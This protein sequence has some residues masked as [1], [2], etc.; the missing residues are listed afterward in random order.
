MPF[1]EIV[2]DDISRGENTGVDQRKIDERQCVLA[3][4]MEYHE[5][6]DLRARTG[7]K[8]LTVSNP[9]L[10]AQGSIVS[11]VVDE[12]HFML[13][14]S[15]GEYVYCTDGGT[16]DKVLIIDV[17][18]PATSHIV[19]SFSHGTMTNPTG[20]ALD[21]TNGLLY[22][23][24][25]QYIFVINI[26]DPEDPTY[27][28]HVSNALLTYQ[29]HLVLVG[30]YLYSADS[31][32]D[33]VGVWD[34]TT[35]AAPTYHTRLVDAVD[36]NGAEGICVDDAGDY[37][38]VSAN[39]N[40]SLT[41]VDIT[42]P[43][44]PVKHGTMAPDATN[45]NELAYIEYDGGADV[46]YGI[47]SP[48][49]FSSQGSLVTIDVSNRAAPA[50]LDKISC[51]SVSL[52]G[53]FSG[54]LTRIGGYAY[55]AVGNSDKI[56]IVDVSDPG[57][58]SETGVI[59]GGNV[60]DNVCIVAL[61]NSVLL[62]GSRDDDLILA[63]T[64]LPSVPPS[65][66]DSYDNSSPIGFGKGGYWHELSDGTAEYYKTDGVD[67][68]I[69]KYTIDADGNITYVGVSANPTYMNDVRSCA[70]Y[71][72]NDKKFLVTWALNST[73]PMVAIWDITSSF[74]LTG[75]PLWYS[76]LGTGS[77]TGTDGLWAGQL[78]DGRFYVVVFVDTS[79]VSSTLLARVWDVDDLGAG[80]V[81]SIGYSLLDDGTSDNAAT[82]SG[83]RVIKHHTLDYLFFKAQTAGGLPY[84]IGVL[85]LTDPTNP[86][87]EA[88]ITPAGFDDFCQHASEDRLYVSNA[89]SLRT[90]NSTDP[91]SLS[92]V[93]TV[94]FAD[95]SSG[96]LC[97]ND[98]ILAL[99]VGSTDTVVAFWLNKDLP[100]KVGYLTDGTNLNVAAALFVRYRSSGG[101]GFGTV[102]RY[103]PLEGDT[104]ASRLTTVSL[105][106]IQSTTLSNVLQ[107][108]YLTNVRGMMGDSNW[109]YVAASGDDAF[110]VLNISD[111]A[112]PY[113]A[114]EIVS[115]TYF[116]A[117]ADV[118]FDEDQDLC[119]TVSDGTNKY[120]SVIDVSDPEN[121]VRLGSVQNNTA[122]AGARQICKISDRYFAVAAFTYDGISIIDINDTSNPTVVATLTDGTELNG[123]SGV[124]SDGTTLW[125]TAELSNQIQPID[126]SAIGTPTLVGTT[127]LTDA[128]KLAGC[129]RL[130]YYDGYLYTIGQDNSYFYVAEVSTPF[131]P[132]EAFSETHA[133]ITNP[134]D[135]WVDGINARAFVASYNNDQIVSY[136]IADPTACTRSVAFTSATKLDGP[137]VVYASGAACFAS[138]DGEDRV[139]SILVNGYPLP[140]PITSIHQFNSIDGVRHTILTAGPAVYEVDLTSGEFT[141]I[142]GTKILPPTAEWHWTNYDG[143]AVGVNGGGTGYDNPVYWDGVAGSISTLADAPT[144][145]QYIEL[146]NHRAVAS[147]GYTLYWS[148]LGDITNWSDPILSG[149]V[150]IDADY[151]GDITGLVA[152]KG[153][154]IIFK[155]NNVW[156]LLPGTPNTDTDQWSIERVISGHGCLN[157]SSA[158]AILDDVFFLSKEGLLSLGTML[159]VGD[160]EASQVS[161]NIAE[162]E[163]LRTDDRYPSVVD[164]VH[165]Q[166]WI[167]APSSG[168]PGDDNNITYVFDFSNMQE[169]LKWTRFTGDIVGECYATG[170]DDA[171]DVVVFIGGYN[172]LFVR[173][174]TTD[175]NPYEDDTSGAVDQDFLSKEV[176]FGV[177][178]KRKAMNRFGINVK[179]LT[180]NLDINFEIRFNG[181][182]SAS[183]SYTFTLD[184]VGVVGDDIE[185]IRKLIG[186]AGKNA[187]SYQYRVRNNASN[188]A[189]GLN[190]L[191]FEVS[192]I[193]HTRVNEV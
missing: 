134:L 188:E 35:P 85:N 159:Q 47:A 81:P 67:D 60:D 26:S 36:L 105:T 43:G 182:G 175:T 31:S 148:K 88:G 153:F 136:L 185:I 64:I 19:G 145:A 90:F 54:Q 170:K 128:T 95:S 37:L 132:T 18:D 71:E 46:V 45:L 147:D 13:A 130:R 102:N 120:V 103:I 154:L 118:Y 98:N 10:T 9:A 63:F 75:T 23:S 193:T 25:S 114:A 190:T 135:I 70:V 14:D 177:P 192:G 179:K 59:Q 42:T 143:V 180:S 61:G 20:M 144:G 29:N 84:R 79:S 163:G 92:L 57:N 119:V 178:F 96:I 4:N 86:T 111:P 78:S 162:L 172:D 100:I 62:T 166:Y 189:F 123:C 184:A 109:L 52:S 39:D 107:S 40:D 38:F 168:T 5:D 82:S 171:N 65:V 140:Y 139:V 181:S 115:S 108:Q 24:S 48:T 15:A 21:E 104:W 121:P 150:E 53:Q 183:H 97:V 101:I 157:G 137:V 50:Y 129:L 122:F 158:R 176:D 146:F 152:H 116:D 58:L 6:G 73:N 74:A 44:T 33:A 151:D 127:P 51:S 191:M 87:A 77:A 17:T 91:T 80:G 149:A 106:G 161:D 125:A 124:A 7:A 11:A 76:G 30:S 89:T 174:K 141:N 66:L 165:S 186:A 34:C 12:P 93:S 164:P 117:I 110:T 2:Y 32:Q 138:V 8:R 27:V 49:G 55:V 3:K 94:T 160:Y 169:G 156:R 83:C 142:T 187:L 112:E 113:R 131:A 56:T 68:A 72:N 155:E 28:T 133:D 126:I 167:S 16:N 173:K 41:V 69:Y 1:T 22:V 99:S